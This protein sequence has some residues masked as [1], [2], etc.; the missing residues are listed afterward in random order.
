M[1]FN[2]QI[3]HNKETHMR[4]RQTSVAEFTNSRHL[5]SQHKQTSNEEGVRKRWFTE[6]TGLRIT[7]TTSILQ[8]I[9]T[10]FWNCQKYGAKWFRNKCCFNPCSS[11]SFTCG[12]MSPT[13]F[14]DSDF[15]P[16]KCSDKIHWKTT[17]SHHAFRTGKILQSRTYLSI[18]HN[19]PMLTQM[20]KNLPFLHGY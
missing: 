10:D 18:I 16:M 15:S 11:S 4:V 1:T 13:Y 20:V 8:V 2:S 6:H 3:T 17:N 5:D 12:P 9:S 14:S 7:K 19:H